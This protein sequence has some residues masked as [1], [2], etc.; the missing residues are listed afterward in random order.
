MI[1]TWFCQWRLR[2]A[3]RRGDDRATIYW[4]HRINEE[5]ER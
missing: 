2:A 5:F 4:T 3:H 1:W